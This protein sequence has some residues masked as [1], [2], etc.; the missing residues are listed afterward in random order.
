MRFLELARIRPNEKL[1]RTKA[2]PKLRAGRFFLNFARTTPLFP[3][4]RVTLPQIT[5]IFVYSPS[6]SFFPLISS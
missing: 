1:S 5:R 6:V 2:A 4:G 3:C